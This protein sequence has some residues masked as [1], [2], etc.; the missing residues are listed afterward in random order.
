MK[1][2]PLIVGIA[3][4]LAKI[5]VTLAMV[6]A[7]RQQAL[8]VFTSAVNVGYDQLENKFGGAPADA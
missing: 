5:V 3:S 4:S 1:A 8:E 2:H 6:G 7:T